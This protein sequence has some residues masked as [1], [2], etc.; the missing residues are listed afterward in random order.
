MIWFK[1]W[2]YLAT[3]CHH[4]FLVLE[5]RW[6]R[7]YC[8]S[9]MHSQSWVSGSSQI[10]L[11]GHFLPPSPTSSAQRCFWTRPLPGLP[12]Q[13]SEGP[14]EEDEELL[15]K[16][17]RSPP[18]LTFL[19][20]HWIPGP[21]PSCN[22]LQNI[23]S[24]PF[25]LLGI[26]AAIFFP[27]WFS[28]NWRKIASQYCVGLYYTSARVRAIGIHMLPPS[29]TSHPPPTPLGGNR[30]LVW[31]PLSHTANSHWLSI[32][33]MIVYIYIAAAI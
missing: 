8:E 16:Q 33:Y 21:F 28:F 23:S 11:W 22:S 2:K 4:W 3:V 31:V 27:N 25:L 10:T 12:V 26:E 20:G 1:S 13:L 29:L 6:S 5:K 7:I 18:T 17:A 19:P 24:G 15:L 30:T 32:L 14:K 9:F